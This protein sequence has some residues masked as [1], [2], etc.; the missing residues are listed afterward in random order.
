M[1]DKNRKGLNH[2]LGVDNLSP[3]QEAM[4]I[5]KARKEVAKKLG[6]DPRKKVLADDLYIETKIDLTPT[7]EPVNYAGHTQAD[8]NRIAE[9]WLTRP[10]S[11]THFQ[12]KLKNIQKKPKVIKKTGVANNFSVDTSALKPKE[13]FKYTSRID[14]L[15][16]AD[17]MTDD[18][19]KLKMTGPNAKNLTDKEKAKPMPILTY[20]DKMSNLYDGKPR[21]YDDKGQ[22]L[23]KEQHP[24]DKYYEDRIKEIDEKGTSWASK[25]FRKQDEKAEVERLQKL[26]EKNKK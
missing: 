10:P 22:P 26:V 7:K 23:K 4:E 5:Q 12:D 11:A 25:H 3:E 18:L 16:K 6:I 19:H 13:K 15:A 21:Q 8:K 17:K 20:V 1:S 9:A 2:L 14:E 24:Q